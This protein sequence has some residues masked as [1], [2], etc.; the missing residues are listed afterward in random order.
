MGT[1]SSL[2]GEKKSPERKGKRSYSQSTFKK[3]W[4]CFSPI[5]PP[6]QEIQLTCRYLSLYK[7]YWTCIPLTTGDIILYPAVYLED[8]KFYPAVYLE[9]LDLKWK[10]A[11]QFSL[12]KPQRQKITSSACFQ[13]AWGVTRFWYTTSFIKEPS[14]V[15]VPNTPGKI[16]GKH[17]V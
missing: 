14:E 5:I 2:T 12:G 11:F 4:V 1:Q 13:G 7:L 10:T 6:I 8:Y 16:Q 3:F 15:Y 17:V 9:E